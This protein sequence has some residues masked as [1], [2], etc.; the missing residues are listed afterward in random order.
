LE[1]HYPIV[2]LA[3]AVFII[4]ETSNS[5]DSSTAKWI[6]R[7]RIFSTADTTPA[8]PNYHHNKNKVFPLSKEILAEWAEENRE[9]AVNF[10]DKF[11]GI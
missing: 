4:I 7:G 10:G 1:K 5:Y 11:I 3:H 9:A 2:A 6:R 8:P